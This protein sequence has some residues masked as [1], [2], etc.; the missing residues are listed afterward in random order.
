MNK[1]LNPTSAPLIKKNYMSLSIKASAETFNQQAVKTNY[2]R[3]V[4]VSKLR[5]VLQ[6]QH[7]I[8]PDSVFL[9]LN[10]QTRMVRKTN[11]PMQNR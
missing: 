4:T 9:Q 5:Y 1:T 8:Q 11:H 3:K 6:S 10:V 2:C 7:Y